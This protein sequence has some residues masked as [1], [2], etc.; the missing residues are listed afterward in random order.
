MK[1][2][3]ITGA[4][5][6]IGLQTAKILLG[7]GHEVIVSGRDNDKLDKLK[8]ELSEFSD[9]FHTLHMDV[10]DDESVH[11]ASQEIRSQFKKLDVLINNAG[12]FLDYLDSTDVKIDQMK[13]TMETNFYGPLRTSQ[14]FLGMLYDSDDGRIINIS[15][16]MGA[17]SE[18][19]G[20]SASYRVSKT[21]LNSLTAIMS[22]DVQGGITVVAACP[23]WV[24]TDMGGSGAPRSLE[25][26]A[27]GIVELATRPVLESGKFYRD[28]IE[29]SW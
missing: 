19:M 6:G 3:L 25:K 28:G 16:G 29:I 22:S 23:G 15:S 2:I 1:T 12:I 17:F 5:R 7:L 26:G 21:A 13:K 24:R 20:G 27:S 9:R 8:R 10:T 14:A 11:D 4:T 18:M